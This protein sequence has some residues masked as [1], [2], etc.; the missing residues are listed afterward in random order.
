MSSLPEGAQVEHKV[1]TS[2]QVM[3]VLLMKKV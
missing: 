3:Q 1:T 2:E